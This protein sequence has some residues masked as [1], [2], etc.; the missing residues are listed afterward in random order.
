MYT[1]GNDSSQKFSPSPT[2]IVFPTSMDMVHALVQKANELSFAIVPSGGRTGLS[3]GA[4][5]TTG[6]VVVA[7]E[8]M[9][10]DK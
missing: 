6:E 4:C 10:K 8:K 9:N 7:L 5:A 2:A 3:G 1:Y